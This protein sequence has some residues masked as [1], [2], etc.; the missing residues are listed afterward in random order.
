MVTLWFEACI[1]RTCAMAKYLPWDSPE[2]NLYEQI[3]LTYNTESSK[4]SNVYSKECWTI[5]ESD[6]YM[7]FRSATL[8]LWT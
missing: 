7:K 2:I 5:V 3:S 1:Y 6:I 4:A 8:P